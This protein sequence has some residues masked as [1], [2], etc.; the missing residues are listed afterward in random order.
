MHY[1]VFCTLI[2]KIKQGYA[3]LRMVTLVYMKNKLKRKAQLLRKRGLTYSEIRKTIPVS[4][5]TLS[6]WLREVGLTKIQKQKITEKR[7]KASL[8]GA[9]QRRRDRIERT[10]KIYSDVKIK[11][12]NL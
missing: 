12:G 10:N 11:I 1:I 2:N 9:Q 7:L 6:L 8:R 4:K 5:S 3:I